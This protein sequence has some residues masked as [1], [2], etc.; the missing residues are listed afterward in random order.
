LLPSLLQMLGPEF[1]ITAEPATE[2]H[3]MRRSVIQQHIQLKR[4]QRQGK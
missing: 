4:R 2:L 3:G 1:T